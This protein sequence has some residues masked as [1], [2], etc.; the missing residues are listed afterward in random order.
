MCLAPSSIFSVAHDCPLLSV[1]ER[2]TAE[3]VFDDDEEE[4]PPRDLAEKWFVPFPPSC[5]AFEFVLAA[6][7]PESLVL[8]RGPESENN[9]P[10]TCEEVHRWIF[11]FFKKM[12]M[13]HVW[14]RFC[15]HHREDEPFQFLEISTVSQVK[16]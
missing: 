10:D 13:K 12:L 6:A 15:K 3:F 14:E 4:S 5:E 2:K 8:R 9:L 11:F 7:S 16:E 1:T